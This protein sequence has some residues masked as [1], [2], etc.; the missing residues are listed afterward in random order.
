MARKVTHDISLPSDMFDD[1]NTWKND[2]QE[3]A[4]DYARDAEDSPFT[5]YVMP[6]TWI[7]ELVDGDFDSWECTVRV[8]RLS[9]V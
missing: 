6:C 1:K 4:I 9:E 3:Y 2:M 7:A 5:D 8:T